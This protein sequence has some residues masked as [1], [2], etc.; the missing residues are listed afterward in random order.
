[1]NHVNIVTCL[2]LHR[3]ALHSVWNTLSWK[4]HVIETVVGIVVINATV[5]M[6]AP[7]GEPL[8]TELDKRDLFTL[9]T[10]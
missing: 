6:A 10:R 4:V 9:D 7:Q 2:S 1:M 8:E 3:V 5:R